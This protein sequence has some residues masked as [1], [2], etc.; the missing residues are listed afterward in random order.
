MEEK[1]V[2]LTQEGYEQIRRGIKL[3]KNRKKI[4]NC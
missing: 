4:R 3:F 2:I 1:E